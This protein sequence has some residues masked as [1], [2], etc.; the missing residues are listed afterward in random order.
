MDPSED[1]VAGHELDVAEA[2]DALE[3]PGECGDVWPD[4]F[5]EDDFPF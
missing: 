1:T 2:F 4:N 3:Y 5:Y